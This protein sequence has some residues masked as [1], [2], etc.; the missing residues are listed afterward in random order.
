VNQASAR[1]QGVL[2]DGIGTLG[3]LRKDDWTAEATEHVRDAQRVVAAAKERP[4]RFVGEATIIDCRK[5]T[6]L[7][8]TCVCCLSAGD[9]DAAHEEDDP[10]NQAAHARFHLGGLPVRLGNSSWAEI[11]RD[12][13]D[14]EGQS[15]SATRSKTRRTRRLVCTS[16]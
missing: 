16:R 9:G 2:A 10:E 11:R 3:T 14:L 4:T 7:E 8:R 12:A 5:G 6:T 13:I 1:V 15:A